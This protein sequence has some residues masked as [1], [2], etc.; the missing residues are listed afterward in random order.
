MWERLGA[1]PALPSRT[2]SAP[3]ALRGRIAPPADI[4][5]S[6]LPDVSGK[7]PVR[8]DQLHA[9]ITMLDRDERRSDRL[10]NARP[11]SDVHLSMIEDSLAKLG[12]ADLLA[13][14]NGLLDRS[15][16]LAAML[17]DARGDANKQHTAVMNLLLAGKATA[18]EVIAQTSRAA[19]LDP[20]SGEAG[21]MIDKARKVLAG[22][23]H[24][25]AKEQGPAIEARLGEIARAAARESAET[26]A[27]LPAGVTSDR[28]AMRMGGEAVA[29][30]SALDEL[31]GRYWLCHEVAGHLRELRWIST[32]EATTLAEHEE[33][34]LESEPSPVELN[35]EHFARFRKAD[36]I[37][38]QFSRQ[39]TGMI[40]EYRKVHPVLRLAYAESL[41]AEPGLY[42]ADFAC[43]EYRKWVSAVKRGTEASYRKTT[44]GSPIPSEIF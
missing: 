44:E 18:D 1:L 16:E 22:Q 39:Y 31:R 42:P 2:R 41:G 40:L 3:A 38:D 4:A 11:S 19:A 25:A 30:W 9:Q 10:L 21:R 43:R 26:A 17:R 23:A 14:S 37:V 27:R 36:R 32:F 29:A 5:P 24:R 34:D 33:R 7:T 12:A 28:T 20:E 13:T 35:R 6:D 15:E 8:A